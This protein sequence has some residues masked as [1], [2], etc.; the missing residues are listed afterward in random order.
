[1]DDKGMST[2]NT[3]VHMTVIHVALLENMLILFFCGQRFFYWLFTLVVSNESC[4]P[5]LAIIS[6]RCK[7]KNIPMPTLVTVT[8]W[9]G[10]LKASIVT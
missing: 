9:L 4:H 2:S 8:E 6:S 5:N 1:M 3:K 10:H 7:S